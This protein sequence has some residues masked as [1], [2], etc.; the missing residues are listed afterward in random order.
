L[1]LDYRLFI[2]S[3]VSPQPLL[4][5]AMPEVKISPYDLV[6]LVDDN[7]TYNFINRRILE[8]A[9]FAKTVEVQSSGISALSYLEEHINDIGRLPDIIFLDIKMPHLNGHEFLYKLDR[10]TN[11]IEDKCK[12]VMLSAS[13]EENDVVK[14]KEYDKVINYIQK[15]LT[16]EALNRIN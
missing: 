8:N 3:F 4:L 14:S 15:P 12:V 10:I 2:L 7:D 13:V 9:K 11:G 6:M 16:V 5:N 1:N